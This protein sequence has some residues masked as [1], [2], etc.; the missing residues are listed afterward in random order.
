[1]GRDK[2]SVEL[3]GVPM[4][5]HVVAA[6]RR[7]GCEPLVVGRDSAPPNTATVPDDL[8][9]RAGPAVGLVTVLRRAAGRDVVLVATDQPLLRSRTVRELLALDGD[10]VAPL[11]AGMRQATCAVY[12]KSCL[13]PLEDLI[14]N[15]P[16]LPLQRLLDRVA[17]TDVPEDT[18]SLWGEDGR[19]WW[20]LDA[21]GDVAEAEEWLRLGGESRIESRES[22][23]DR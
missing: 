23:T 11:D 3:N 20:S 22:N 7:A 13:G 10:A 18:W 14:R 15:G 4:L 2:A 1:M 16:S 19:S 12:R 6:V 8:P 17:T 9:G 5:D 21:P